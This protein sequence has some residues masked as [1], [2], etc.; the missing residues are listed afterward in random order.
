MKQVTR[1]KAD[2]CKKI[3]RFIPEK[4]YVHAIFVGAEKRAKGLT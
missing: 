1:F 4:V 3:L 2:A